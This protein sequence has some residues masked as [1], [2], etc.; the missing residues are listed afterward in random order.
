MMILAFAGS[1]SSKSINHQFIEYVASQLNEH[2][3]EIIRLTDYDL[4]IYSI[5]IENNDFPENVRVLHKKLRTADGIIISVA[6]HNGNITAFFKSFVDWISRYD[7]EFLKD[8]KW[9]LLSTA[10]GKRGGASALAIAK[11][12]LDYFKGE[13][14]GTYSLS[15]FKSNLVNGELVD[16]FIKDEVNQLIKRFGKSLSWRREGMN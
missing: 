8:K 4:P 11:K 2:N 13:L 3:V 6:E 1:N 12:T 5:D 9:L 14:I 7:R 16:R 15:N 10:P